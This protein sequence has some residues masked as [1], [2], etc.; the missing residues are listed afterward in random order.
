MENPIC[1]LVFIYIYTFPNFL[2]EADLIN[3]KI[4]LYKLSFIDFKTNKMD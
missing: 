2:I 1:H 3:C 4:V